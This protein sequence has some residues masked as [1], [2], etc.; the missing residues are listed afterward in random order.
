MDR[1]LELQVQSQILAIAEGL[2]VPD[3]TTWLWFEPAQL[4]LICQAIAKQA[5]RAADSASA[6]PAE[7]SP[8]LE[9]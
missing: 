2:G 4:K 8:T 3:P 7:P 1:R 9:S 5:A 6:T